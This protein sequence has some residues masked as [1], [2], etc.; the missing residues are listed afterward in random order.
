MSWRNNS[1]HQSDIDT[2]NSFSEIEFETNGRALTIEFDYENSDVES[3]LSNYASTARKIYFNLTFP[4]REDYSGN[5][6][7]KYEIEEII[8]IL[9]DE[10]INLSNIEVTFRLERK[11]LGQLACA[12][13]FRKIHNRGATFK[14]Y[15]EGQFQD[16]VRMN[17]QWFEQLEDEDSSENYIYYYE[18]DCESDEDIAYEYT[19]DDDSD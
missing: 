11:H 16:S 12:L 2:D 10:F 8:R 4:T 18:S 5:E 19:T 14:Y 1:R 17:S 3:N 6:R 9:N 15:V 7:I 13:P